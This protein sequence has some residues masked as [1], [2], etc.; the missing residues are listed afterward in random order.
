MAKTKRLKSVKG[1][2]WKKGQSS[3]SNP[4]TMKHREAARKVQFQVNTGPS[5]LTL[6]A[7]AK[8][9][10][11]C[12]DIGSSDVDT[13]S[14]ASFN[15]WATNFTNTTNAT[16]SKVN[17]YWSSG[18][19]FHNEVLAILAAVT[20]VIKEQGGTES[21]TEY[22]GALITTLDTVQ[23]EQSVAAVL[24]L[25]NMAIKKTPQPVLRKSFTEAAK[26]LYDVFAEH[27]QGDNQ[28]IIKSSL[29]CLSGLLRAQDQ[30]AWGDSSTTNI[31]QSLLT[32]TVHKKPRVRKCAQQAVCII[33]KTPE[34]IQNKTA[35][36]HPAAA[37]TASFCQE[38]IEQ[39]G[40]DS[41]TTLYV[42]GLLQHLL[43]SF[44]QN[45]LKNTVQ[46]I[47]AAMT[48]SN[49]VV[50]SV[51]LKALHGLFKNRPSITSLPPQRNSQIILALYEFQPSESDTQPM[52]AWMMVIEAAFLNLSEH[53]SKLCLDR[54]PRLV[55]ACMNCMSR[56]DS[57]QSAANTLISVFKTCLPA[58]K[59]HLSV[60][61]QSPQP[62]NIHKIITTFE[63]GLAS[64]QNH[65][66]WG[67][68]L[69]VIRAMFLAVGAVIDPL[70][71]K[72]LL[73]M[74]TMRTTDAIHDF[75]YRMEVDNA[76]GAAVKTMGP[77][78]V[79][80]AVPLQ[81]TGEEDN[82]DFPRSWLIP[83]IR[84]NVTNTSLA[85]F[86][87]YFLPLATKLRNQSLEYSYGGRSVEG[88]S[89]D[90]LQDQ[91]WSMLPGFCTHPTDLPK[92]FPVLAQT[93]GKALK[94]RPDLRFN[95]LSGIRKLIQHSNTDEES[96]K[97]M[98]LFAKNFIPLLFNL[99]TSDPE[100]ERDPKRMAVLDTAKFYFQVSK[101]IKI[102]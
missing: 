81:I 23:E 55:T 86:N 24:Y 89:Y 92:A 73:S 38:K 94:D 32:F 96:K 59:E 31:F 25:L 57:S 44:P 3:N 70:C 48:L 19:A 72:L 90:A 51:A 68:I 69:N 95:V 79:L 47:L 33:L 74:S 71:H 82:Y 29:Q 34:F 40:A 41:T 15:T 91:I 88:K 9:D 6:S 36:H 16:F 21:E 76:V 93:L 14:V 43:S 99:Y 98:S 85:Y 28:T 30:S 87:S 67:L 75:Q 101:N 80:E 65:A 46:S 77:K 78:S 13:Q 2:R 66:S 52:A 102:R 20:E 53:D 97:V 84:D 45:S 8:H 5:E 11:Q 100:A 4:Q 39:A 42:M 37:A 60:L 50:K 7:L 63:N 62:T 10:A 49:I 26:K 58:M 61:V 64:Y 27:A 35:A 54:L 12:M 22:Y 83:V 18:S 1:K 56:S 17:R